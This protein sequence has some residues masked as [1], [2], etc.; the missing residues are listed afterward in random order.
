MILESQPLICRSDAM[1][2]TE[3]KLRQLASEDRSVLLHGESAVGM[4]FISRHIHQTSQRRDHPLVEVGCA[5]IP[6]V[7]F[8]HTLFGSNGPGAYHSASRGT[9]LLRAFQEVPTALQRDLL[10]GVSAGIP[11]ADAPRIVATCYG[12]PFRHEEV[13]PEVLLQF[14]ILRMPPL[15]ERLSD[16]RQLAELFIRAA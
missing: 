7:N 15:R 1:R 12:D 9:L 16:I 11:I 6:E 2:D 3:Q 5:A 13:I 8:A 14:T 4:G 10:R